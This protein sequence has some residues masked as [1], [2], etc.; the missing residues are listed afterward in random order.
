M[1]ELHEVAVVA[2]FGQLVAVV[3]P[4]VVHMPVLPAV[5]THCCRPVDVVVH[6]LHAML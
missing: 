3:L 6:S 2:M 4:N 5:S 1:T